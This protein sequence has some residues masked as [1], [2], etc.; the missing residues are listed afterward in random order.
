M[1][2]RDDRSFILKKGAERTAVCHAL[3]FFAVKLPGDAQK[4]RQLFL[5]QAPSAPELRPFL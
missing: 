3:R 1:V 5:T 2:V 4:I